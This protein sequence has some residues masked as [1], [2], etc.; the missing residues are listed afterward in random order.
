MPVFQNHFY[1]K[2]ISLLTGVFGSVFDDLKLVRAD[3]T[4][5]RVPIAYAVKRKYNVRN[6]QNPDPNAVRYKMQLPRMSFKLIGLRR[7]T[8]RI[9]NKMYQ[10]LENVDRSQ[11]TQMSSQL[12]RVPFIF[13]F[14]LSLKTKTIDDMLQLIEQ[15]M[16]YFN[17]SLNVIVKDNPDIDQGSAINIKLIDAGIEDISEGMFDGEESLE[18]NMQFDMEGW[19]YMPTQTSKVITKVIVNTFDLGD[20]GELLDTVIEVP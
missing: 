2:T 8:T 12:N 19:L 14:Q 1:H 18:V 3:G 17:P 16:V 5:I 10:L 13:N 6:D 20:S 9:S 4:T 11:V 7:D 15:I